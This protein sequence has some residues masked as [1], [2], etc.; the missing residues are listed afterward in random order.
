M[1]HLVG[2]YF[3]FK[4]G[5]IG[6]LYHIVLSFTRL[7]ISRQWDK[8]GPWRPLI[9]IALLLGRARGGDLCW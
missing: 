1:Y 9:E 3:G 8:K 4:A 7:A 5:T 6:K 2:F